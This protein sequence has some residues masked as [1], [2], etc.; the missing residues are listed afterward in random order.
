MEKFWDLDTIGIAEEESSVY[1]EFI[2]DMKFNR[3]RFSV[4]LPLKE[5][6]PILLDNFN[7]CERRL[8]KLKC[9]LDQN[10]ELLKEYDDI[11]KDQLSKGVIEEAD[12][13][14]IPGVLHIYL[15]MKL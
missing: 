3:N 13:K 10:P 9:R 1:N 12:T 5:M 7:F 6:H 2:K 11:F 14:G 8:K 4:K 15:I